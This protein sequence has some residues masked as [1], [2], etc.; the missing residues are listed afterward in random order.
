MNGALNPQAETALIDACNPQT[1]AAM[2]DALNPQ[3]GRL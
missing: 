3:S 2:T 1:E